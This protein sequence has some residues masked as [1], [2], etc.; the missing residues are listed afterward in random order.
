MVSHQVYLD[1]NAFRDVF[2][3]VTGFSTLIPGSYQVNIHT[4]IIPLVSFV[5]IGVFLMVSAMLPIFGMETQSLLKA[6]RGKD[7]HLY[8]DEPESVEPPPEIQDN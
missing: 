2:V 6:L 1:T 7:K 4:K 5:W 8:E 3:T